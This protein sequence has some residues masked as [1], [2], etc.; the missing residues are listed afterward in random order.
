SSFL[1]TNLFLLWGNDRWLNLAQWFAMLS[2]AILLTW[3]VEQL[4]V[5]GRKYDDVTQVSKPAVSPTSQSADRPLS[6][7][8]RI[9][10]SARQQVW[11]PVLQNTSPN[12]RPGALSASDKSEPDAR[13][14]ARRLRSAA[15]T[16]A[17]AI[18]LP[19]G[20]VEA[21]STQNDYTTAFWVLCVFALG[22]L[23]LKSPTNP[24]YV[25]AA[26]L[27]CGLGALTKATTYIYC[28]PLIL[29]GGL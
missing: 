5:G 27:S 11:K 16:S 3:I 2:S 23:L 24:W 10:K 14:S 19:I 1:M 7:R 9:W 13:Q 22:F 15:F 17:F 29:A 8:L 21:I 12:L 20:M 26:S 25:A 28:A 4:S 18:T 6:G